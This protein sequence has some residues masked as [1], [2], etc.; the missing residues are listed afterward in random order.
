MNKWI[1]SIAVMIVILSI[2]SLLLPDGKTGK[3]IKSFFSL[4]L[5]LV[6]LQPVAEFK[7]IDIGNINLSGQNDIVI[8]NDY[9]EYINNE[10]NNSQKKQIKNILSQKGINSSEVNIK[11]KTDQN[12][13]ITY[14]KVI[15]NIDNKVI[16]DEN[17]HIDINVD[18]VKATADYL[19]ISENRVIVNV[20]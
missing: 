5:I 14:E 16:K 13:Q 11:C 17:Q 1:L 20:V 12:H 19:K 2:S 8:Q 9:I 6:I 15:I 4:I 3:Y 10:K 7:K 18:I